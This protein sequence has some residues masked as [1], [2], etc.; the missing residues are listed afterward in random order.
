MWRGPA[1]R[2]FTTG[3]LLG[4]ASTGLLA[5]I[6]GSLVRPLV[7]IEMGTLL[8]AA[9]G[10][11]IIVAEIAGYRLA[12]PQNARQVPTWIIREGSRAG[13][14]QFGYEM[15]TGVRTYMTSSLPHA[16][17]LAV[18]VQ[19]SWWQGLVAGAAFGGGRAAMALT[20]YYHGDTDRWD[21]LL[22]LHSARARVLLAATAAAALYF[23]IS[24]TLALL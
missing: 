17:L 19:A 23:I 6:V 10:V 7:P 8:L 24:P 3:L 14:L 11:I 2:L 18:L 9:G 1:L 16:A 15:G 5:V 20:R 4:G 12:L 13:A 21:H 22:R